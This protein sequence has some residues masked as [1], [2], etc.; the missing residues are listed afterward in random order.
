VA[1]RVDTVG[2]LIGDID[3]VVAAVAS[4]PQRMPDAL[5]AE[6]GSRVDDALADRLAQAYAEG[7]D[8]MDD[9]RGSRWY[10]QKMIDV[11]VRRA[12]AALRDQSSSAEGA[13][14]G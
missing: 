9:A 1:A 2:G 3:V 12:L 10:R 7:I 4:T 11:F 8:A 13:R 5:Q 14:R 6:I